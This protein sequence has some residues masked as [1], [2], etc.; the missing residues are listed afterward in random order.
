[1]KPSKEAS[2]MKLKAR[3]FSLLIAAAAIAAMPYESKAIP[4]P[5]AINWGAS[6]TVFVSSLYTGVL[7]RAPE[8][9]AV[10]SG[11][12]AKIDSNP[13]SRLSVFWGFVNSPEYQSSR[14]AK[15][16]KDHNLFQKYD[17]RANRYLYAVGNAS[18]GADWRVAYGPTTFGIAAA[19]RGYYNTYVTRR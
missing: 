4:N 1:M 5:N 6:P 3:F 13:S 2:Y 14:W 15:F 10:V 16:K 11:W 19:L 18:L 7:G 17:S 9:A 8:S 12:A